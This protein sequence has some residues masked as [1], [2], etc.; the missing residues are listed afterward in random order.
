MSASEDELNVLGSEQEQDV[1][2]CLI[3]QVIAEVPAGL[4]RS[5]IFISELVVDKGLAR[6]W[7]VA[8]PTEMAKRVKQKQNRGKRMQRKLP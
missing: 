8:N 6:K 3:A 7:M 2:G 1:P 4:C 5:L